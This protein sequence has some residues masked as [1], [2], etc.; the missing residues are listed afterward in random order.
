MPQTTDSKTIAFVGLGAMGLGMAQSCLRA[1]HRVLGIDLNP[2]AVDRLVEAGGEKLTPEGAR[3]ASIFVSVVLN[4]AQTREILYGESGFA[5]HLP[6]GAVIV[7]SATVSPDDARG[8]AQQAA[9]LGLLYLDAPISGGA[10]RAAQG[11]L[12]IMASGSQ[13]TFEAAAP[14]LSAMAQSVHDLGREA[15]AG[16]AMKAVNQLLAGVHIAAMGEALALGISQGLEPERILQVISVSAG[17]SWMFENR[18]PRVVE[19][20]Y[21]A[22]SAI[23]IWPKDLGIVTEIAESAA[24]STPV[25]GAALARFREASSKG[26]GALDDAAITRLY[27]AEAG[28]PLPGR[29]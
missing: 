12:S 11:D 20:D 2:A 19:G 14:A 15:G 24:L 16:S 6:R 1:G 28:L 9:Q 5:R 23:D 26:L 8:N 17:T 7:S 10:A 22:R 13:E 4:A 21:E 18:A 27:A 3:D 29:S 25:A